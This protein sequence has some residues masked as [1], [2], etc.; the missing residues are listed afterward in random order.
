MYE[1]PDKELK[2]RILKY[3]DSVSKARNR[4]V[5]R[6]TGAPKEVVDQAIG[7]LAREDKIEYR[8]FG[9]VTYVALKGK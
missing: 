4:D 8:S 5:A 7:G 2:E 9:G 3:L 1:Q 6:A